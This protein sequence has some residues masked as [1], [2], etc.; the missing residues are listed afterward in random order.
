[1]VGEPFWVMRPAP[2]PVG[3]A[4]PRVTVKPSRTAVGSVPDTVTTL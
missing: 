2:V 1:M 3:P 4:L